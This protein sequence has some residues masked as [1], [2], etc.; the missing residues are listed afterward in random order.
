VGLT[1][2]E[3]LITRDELAA[4]DAIWLASALRGLAEATSLDGSPRPR[5][6]W[7][8]RLLRLLGFG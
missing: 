8:P 5:S 7:T 4:C 2:D 1:A 6:P 3:R